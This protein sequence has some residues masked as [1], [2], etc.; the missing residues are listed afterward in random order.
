MTLQF[1][2]LNGHVGLWKW[3]DNRINSSGGVLCREDG[4][5]FLAALRQASAPNTH[6]KVRPC[7]RSSHHGWYFSL[8]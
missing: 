7:V 1:H 8:C 2:F 3:K 4:K 6:L 5:V